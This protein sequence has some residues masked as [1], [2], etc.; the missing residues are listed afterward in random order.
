LLD[1]AT[2]SNLI[3]AIGLAFLT[4]FLLEDFL[5]AGRVFFYRDVHLVWH[6]LIEAVVRVVA[7]GSPPLWDPSPGFGQPLLADPQ[8]QIFYPLT[9]LN[10]VLKPWTYY[11]VLVT[12]HVWF[13]AYGMAVLTRRLGLSAIASF[14]AAALWVTSGPFVSLF[15]NC[16]HLV[17]SAWIPWVILCADRAS[18]SRALRD[19]IL[20]GGAAGLQLLT[21]SPDMAVMTALLVATHLLT[22]R[23][24]WAPGALRTNAHLAAVCA[25]ALLIAV[26]L[27]AGQW[28]PTAAAAAESDRMALP[29]YIR[30]EWSVHP[31]ALLETVYAG[32]W[33]VLPLNARWQETVFKREPFLSSINLGIG[34]W[35]LV[36]V[37]ALGS[38]GRRRG[39][40][41]IGLAAGATLISLGPHT[42]VYPIFAKLFFP[43]RA[44]RY[45]AKA[46]VAAAFCVALAA[47]HGLDAW[48][49]PVV[50]RM[51]GRLLLAFVLFIGLGPAVVAGGLGLDLIPAAWSSHL[52]DA[53]ALSHSA[54]VAHGL[55]TTAVLGAVLAILACIA[56]GSS[57]AASIAGVLVAALTVAH[58]ASSHR[59]LNPSAP[60]SLYTYRPPVVD[61]IRDTVL[62]RVYVYDYGATTEVAAPP[63]TL[64]SAPE[65]W[66][67]AASTALAQEMS[68]SPEAS[69]RWRIDSGYELDSKG[70]YPHLLAQLGLF[71]RHSAGTPVH[72]K[73]LQMG[74]IT[75]VISL[76]EAGFEDLQQ[77][78]SFPGLFDRPIRVYAVPDTRPR[79]YAVGSVR[80]AP[81]LAAF[82]R[83]VEPGF[84][85]SREI[86]LDEA[87]PYDTNDGL[88]GVSRMVSREPDRVRIEAEMARPGYVMLLDQ[89]SP[90][91]QAT[92]DGQETKPLR[93]NLVFRAV[94]VPRGRH[95]IEWTY[96][97]PAAFIGLGVAA[98]T[99][100]LC[101]GLLVAGRF[102]R[103]AVPPDAA[104]PAPHRG[105]PE[106]AARLD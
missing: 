38:P 43:V 44:L 102:R 66:S 29:E 64:A 20:F 104:P 82:R 22:S 63:P 89:F 67:L 90:G 79:T 58:L 61:F 101:F 74:G 65:G 51:R 52:L 17:G 45:P 86:I 62:P 8:T 46:L 14:T 19:V 78:A 95:T 1:R 11:T 21:G 87:G 18:E 34:T 70:L 36:A 97:P 15:S 75:H 48:R 39:L 91:W 76:H 69:G 9:W 7:A 81:G 71:L 28:L 94:A 41:W 26:G 2:R 98:M 50:D 12:L 59:H 84:D 10:L 54:I 49:L 42:P 53:S 60:R 72:R 16:P 6:P 57:R 77:V 5:V 68:L 30:T 32:I 55:T 33:R 73:L 92:I 24:S 100:V 25:A 31:L 3:I 85:P 37:A 47:G 23:A 99:A 83:L 105:G 80:V 88:V 40:V 13:S 103:R 4:V 106:A 35:M 93:A 56:T 96:R 27:S